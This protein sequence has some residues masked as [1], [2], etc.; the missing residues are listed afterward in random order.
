MAESE[1]GL[2]VTYQYEPL[3]FLLDSGLKEL[4]KRNFDEVWSNEPG[5]RF[6]PNHPKWEAMEKGGEAR[7][8]SA[9]FGN[10][11]VGY[12]GLVIT[13]DLADKENVIGVV[14]EIYLAP[15][16]RKGRTGNEFIKHIE[17]QFSTI[18]VRN[19]VISERNGK[20]GPLFKRMGYVTNERIWVKQL[21]GTE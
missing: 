1:F 9:R 21:G 17:R 8:I 18:S 6:N 4:Q 2:M 14:Q 20:N 13:E 7:F 11:L 5:A 16:H 15:E 19:I 10:I 3:A 12:A